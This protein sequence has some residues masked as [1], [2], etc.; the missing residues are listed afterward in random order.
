LHEA[1]IGDTPYRVVETEKGKGVH[2]ADDSGGTKHRQV[3]QEFTPKQATS[4]SDDV[5]AVNTGAAARVNH[6]TGVH[7][8]S[9]GGPDSDGYVGATLTFTSGAK[10]SFNSEDTFELQQ[11]L[12]LT[13]LGEARSEPF[14]LTRVKT[15]AGTTTR[16]NP[17]HDA[18]GQFSSGDGVR[19]TLADAGTVG[20][21]NAAAAAEAKTITGR[22]IAFDL[23]GDPQLARE[24]SE[25]ILRGLERYPGTPL[26]RV[27]GG[28]VEA[29]GTEEKAWASTSADGKTIT[30]QS[31]SDPAAFREDLARNSHGPGFTN[32]FSAATPMGNALHEFGH[33]AANHYGVN[34]PAANT[35]R[36]HVK[37]VIKD[38]DFRAAVGY[39][40]SI[41]AMENSHELVAEAFADVMV[42]GSDA[43]SLSHAIVGT[44]D[45]HIR[46]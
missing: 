6:D 4:L 43:S 22:D 7:V 41:R 35:A 16:F 37:K 38:D 15:R 23:D 25:G 31:H 28:H 42:N 20:Q 36:D 26:Q 46:R 24:H 5:Y 32:E 9:H 19:Q 10:I 13:N 34:E 3:V 8:Q 40:I 14:R 29:H 30:L 1:G 12:H 39:T 11:N 21:V 2:L 44:L 45:S 33:A 18:H 17:H 27:Q